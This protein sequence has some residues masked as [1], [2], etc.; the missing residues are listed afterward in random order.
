MDNVTNTLNINR[1]G[2]ISRSTEACMHLVMQYF[3]SP[4]NVHIRPNVQQVLSSMGYIYR[5][6]PVLFQTMLDSY[7]NNPQT[8]RQFVHLMSQSVPLTSL[9]QPH[10]AWF[11]YICGLYAYFHFGWLKVAIGYHFT[12]QM[13]SGDANVGLKVGLSADQ[14]NKGRGK[15]VGGFVAGSTKKCKATATVET[16][17]SRENQERAFRFQ[18]S[19][20]DNVKVGIEVK[21]NRS[22][23]AFFLAPSRLIRNSNFVVSH[24]INLDGHEIE[25]TVNGLP[26][27]TI[28]GRIEENLK[29]RHK[30]PTSNNPALT[31]TA[32][33]QMLILQPVVPTYQLRRQSTIVKLSL[34]GLLV[35][36]FLIFVKKLVS[37]LKTKKIR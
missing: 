25:T 19:A 35:C 6:N 3:A 22:G 31:K 26:F 30:N 24:N 36:L 33:Q 8:V 28:K 17:L 16:D 20:S 10:A 32:K 14:A 1:I 11:R 5:T 7:L 13:P 27:K 9:N 12:C 4:N 29:S 2:P 23:G 34:L 18:K 21:D 37:F 15:G